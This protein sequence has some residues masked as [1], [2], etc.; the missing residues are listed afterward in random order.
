M[1]V[2]PEEGEEDTQE[3]LD[4]DEIQGTMKTYYNNIEFII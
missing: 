4:E 3:A 2:P 1:Y